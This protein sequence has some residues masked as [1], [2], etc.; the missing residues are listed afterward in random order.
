MGRLAVDRHAAGND[1]FFHVAARTEARF[2]QYFVQL[3]RVVVRGQVAA[4]WLLRAATAAFV[5]VERVRSDEGEGC[6]GIVVATV[7]EGAMDAA[8]LAWLRTAF[9]TLVL[10]FFAAGALFRA[11]TAVAAWLL[12]AVCLRSAAF[13]WRLASTGLTGFACWRIATGCCAFGIECFALAALF[14]H[15]ARATFLTVLARCCLG[16][17]CW[18]AV[19]CCRRC[20]R[21][22]RGLRWRFGC[23][24]GWF[25]WLGGFDWCCGRGLCTGWR[26]GAFGFCDA[27]LALRLVDA[28]SGISFDLRLGTA[29]WLGSSAINSGSGYS[30]RGLSWLHYFLFLG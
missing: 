17:V 23:Y 16:A 6:I 26:I 8:F 27:R 12:R 25:C 2:R 7:A 9:A 29:F 24:F 20:C 14:A 15:L 19:G 18:R 21:R 11:R 1:Q 28:G 5:G 22:C 3:W 13:G 10:A 30:V 4:G